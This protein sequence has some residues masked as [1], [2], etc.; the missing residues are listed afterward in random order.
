MHIGFSLTALGGVLLLAACSGGGAGPA[1]TASTHRAAAAN[2]PSCQSQYASWRTAG[3]MTHFSAVRSAMKANS[4]ALE[5]SVKAGDSGTSLTALATSATNLQSAA[6]AMQ[7]DPP[8]ACIPG[9]QGHMVSAM[10]ALGSVALGE[11]TFARAA[12]AGDT[13]TADSDA[14]AAARQII[15]GTNAMA[16]ADSDISAF[17]GT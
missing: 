16:A 7:A 15:A 11:V 12:Q 17:A 10:S 9:L 2:S 3:G 4:N 5:A 1:A 6:Q 8:P 14:Q 13:S